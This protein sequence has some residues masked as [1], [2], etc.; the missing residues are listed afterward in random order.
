MFRSI[1]VHEVHDLIKSLKNGYK[2][3]I[4][5]QIKG[6][7]LACDYICDAITDLY[8]HS[9]AQGTSLTFSRFQR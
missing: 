3:T 4:G 8:S 1:H 7:K 2:S 9:I 5:V 6:V